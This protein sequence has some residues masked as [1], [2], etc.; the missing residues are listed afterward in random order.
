MWIELKNIF[1]C[2]REERDLKKK[3]ERIEIFRVSVLEVK[4][5]QTL[6]SN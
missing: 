5:A 3:G 2:F 6:P 4:D 1:H